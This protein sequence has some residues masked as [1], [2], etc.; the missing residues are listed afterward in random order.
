[1]D[2]DLK[3]LEEFRKWFN[4]YVVKG[5]GKKC[6]DFAWNCP[7]CHAHFVQAAFGDFVEDVIATEKYFQRKDIIVSK[8][9]K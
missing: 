8:K 6:P 7:A 1:M 3:K 4:G 2:K 9:K 5:Y